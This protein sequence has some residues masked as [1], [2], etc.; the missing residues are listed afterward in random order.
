MGYYARSISSDICIE[1]KNF[2]AILEEAG[3]SLQSP[4]GDVEDRI[5]EWLYG[6]GFTVEFDRDGN[7]ENIWYEYQ[8]FRSSAAEGVMNIIAP[9]ARAGNSISFIGEDEAQWAYV[10]NGHTYKECYGMTVFPE[11]PGDAGAALYGVK[12]AHQYL[13]E[14]FAERADQLDPTIEQ[15]IELLCSHGE[16][17]AEAARTVLLHRLANSQPSTSFLEYAEQIDA[18]V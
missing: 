5:D 2:A 8:K 14:I 17:V 1:K 9:Y 11:V 4:G 3:C 13:C 7:I 16:N 18:L 10:F 15:E 6:V 12:D